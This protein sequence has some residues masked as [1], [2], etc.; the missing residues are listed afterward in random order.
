[1]AERH[2]QISGRLLGSAISFD[3]CLYL[4]D[5]IPFDLELGKLVWRDAVPFNLWLGELAWRGAMPADLWL[6]ES[7]RQR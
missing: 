1:M 5:A 7:R 6:G 3:L 2:A 4:R